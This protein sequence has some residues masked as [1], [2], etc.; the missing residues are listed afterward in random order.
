MTVETRFIIKRTYTSEEKLAHLLDERSRL[1]SR[2][3]EA[4]ML[5]MR[6]EN[7]LSRIDLEI[8]ITQNH[9]RKF[10]N[11]QNMHNL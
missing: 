10:Q 7:E 6:L 8:R 3:A 5:I 1:L 4:K 11:L 9:I 2:L